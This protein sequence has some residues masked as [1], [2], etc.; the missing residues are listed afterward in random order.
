MAKLTTSIEGHDIDRQIELVAEESGIVHT[1][2]FTH[3]SLCKR[4]LIEWHL[5]HFIPIVTTEWL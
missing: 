3:I 2:D 5:F 4:G 1:C